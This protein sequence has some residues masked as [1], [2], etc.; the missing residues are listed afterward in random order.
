MVL[1]PKKLW[2]SYDRKLLP[3]EVYE[4]ARKTAENGEERHVYFNGEAT[5]L[6]CTRIYARLLTPKERTDKLVLVV[7]E[8]KQDVCSVDVS[9][10][11]DNGWAVLIVDY[12]GNVFDHERFTVY[13][14]SLSFG[15]YNEEEL[16]TANDETPQKSCW[17]LWAT[18][19]LRAV[20]FAESEGYSR[21]AMLG[22]GLGG[23]SV[24]KAAA[25]DDY[26]V[27][28]ASLFS[29]GFFPD[30]H[31]SDELLTNVSM[32]VSGYAPLLR[33]PFFQLC[34]SNDSDSS[35]DEISEFLEQSE[36]SSQQS[37]LYIAPR[38]NKSITKEMEAEIVSFFTTYFTSDVRPPLR[39]VA[40][41]LDFSVSGATKKM[42]LSL[43]CPELLQNVSFYISHGITNPA[44]RNW[45]D[46]P[47]EKAGEN[48][49]IGCTEIYSNDRPIYVFA[50]ATTK[51]GFTYCT[52]VLKKMPSALN[53][54]PTTI[55]KRRLIYESDM[56]LDDFF[57]AD[58]QYPISLKEGPFGIGG[59]CAR[60]GL[61]TY[62]IGD[63]MYSG[64]P[65]SVL[66]LL[67]FS[68]AEQEITF[69]VTDED[70]FFT[71]TCTKTVSPATD[72]T[73]IMLS[74]SDFKSSDGF[75]VGWHRAI[76]LRIDA[77]EEFIISSLLWV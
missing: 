45:R 35:L 1:S 54:I 38:V 2:E 58:E 74:P 55:A 64:A 10:L 7:P 56:G 68:S 26:P 37:V 50:A 67:L 21:V 9:F 17:Y 77:K 28:A 70:Q 31:D 36:Q 40:P 27:C 65:D 62:K 44:Y 49:Y 8:P 51:K 24:L 71:Y 72:W 53:L 22:M 11:T 6:G 61:C 29:P 75:F 42:Y 33:I 5:S 19:V 14:T 23:A 13:P 4:I 66:Q 34:C 3:M 73:N 47:V 59:I 63:K 52:P 16:Y 69:S 48:E 60:R 15:N 25:V 20:T 76:F 41:P 30:A 12:A 57:T 39:E 32:D 43:K 18:V 46:L